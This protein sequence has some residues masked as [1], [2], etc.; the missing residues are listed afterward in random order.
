MNELPFNIRTIV[1]A[2]RRANLLPSRN[3]TRVRNRTPPIVV[4]RSP[5]RGFQQSRRIATV[6]GLGRGQNGNQDTQANSDPDS[7]GETIKQRT[8]NIEV[9]VQSPD[10]PS[11]SP[12]PQNPNPTATNPGMLNPTMANQQPGF[13]NSMGPVGG[14]NPF[15]NQRQQPGMDIM[16]GFNRFNPPNS[17]NS[18]ENNNRPSDDRS[19][20]SSNSGGGNINIGL[21]IGVGSSNPVVP[22]KPASTNTPSS[23]FGGVQNVAQNVQPT[24]PNPFPQGFNDQQGGTSS[25]DPMGFSGVPQTGFPGSPQTG[26]P[27]SPQTAFPGSPQNSFSTNDQS[28][29]PPSQISFPSNPQTGFPPNNK[30]QTNT[31]NP[32]V[33]TLQRFDQQPPSLPGAVSSS[34]SMPWNPF[35]SN[36]GN[37]GQDTG[38]LANTN[39]LIN[40]N[41]N[42]LFANNMQRSN[43]NGMQGQ[44]NSFQQSIGMVQP[45]QFNAMPPQQFNNLTSNQNFASSQLLNSQTS[46]GSIGSAVGGFGGVQ[47]PSFLQ[48][49]GNSFQQGSLMGG[50]PTIGEPMIIDNGGRTTVVVDNITFTGVLPPGPPVIKTQVINGKGSVHLNPL[51]SS[52][53][54]TDSFG[55]NFPTQ[56]QFTNPNDLNSINQNFPL[57]AENNQIFPNQQLLGIQATQGT[58]SPVEPQMNQ[59]TSFATPTSIFVNTSGLLNLTKPQGNIDMSLLSNNS[60]LVALNATNQQQM[61]D[62]SIPLNTNPIVA[63]SNNIGTAFSGSNVAVALGKGT[64]SGNVLPSGTNVTGTEGT[65]PID[66]HRHIGE[67]LLVA[68]SSISM[69]PQAFMTSTLPSVDLQG[70]STTKPTNIIVNDPQ[71]Q[72]VNNIPQDIGMSSIVGGIP[73]EISS[74]VTGGISEG[75][76]LTKTGNIPTG[77]SSTITENVPI[78][79]SPVSENILT[80][81]SSS[82]TGNVT[83]RV[84]QIQ[85][86][87]L[88]A[89][90]PQVTDNV[91]TSAE[92]NPI[93]SN[94]LLELQ[95]Q[96]QI[97]QMHRLALLRRR[98]EQLNTLRK[99]LLQIELTGNKR[100]PV[101]RT[102]LTPVKT[103][104]MR[105]LE[106]LKPAATAPKTTASSTV[107][108]MNVDSLRS[109]IEEILHGF[110]KKQNILTGLAVPSSGSAAV[111]DTSKSISP[112]LNTVSRMD[113]KSL[114]QNVVPVQ[115][116]S[117]SLPALLPTTPSNVIKTDPAVSVVDPN[118]IPPTE[119][120]AIDPN[121]VLP[122]EPTPPQ[123]PIVVDPNVAPPTEPTAPSVTDPNII[124][125]R[126]PSVHAH[127][128]VV[129]VS[130]TPVI[131]MQATESFSTILP[132]TTTV[133]P[134]VT[135]P[136]I[137]DSVGSSVGQ[138]SLSGQ[139]R[140]LFPGGIAVHP[141]ISSFRTSNLANFQQPTPPQPQ[142]NFNIPRRGVSLQGI[143]R[144][145]VSSIPEMIGGDLS[146]TNARVIAQQNRPLHNSNFNLQFNRRLQD[147]AMRS[148]VN[149]PLGRPGGVPVPML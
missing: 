85:G 47:N 24:P 51:V 129:T 123:E 70:L 35:P 10:T 89:K 8:V 74:T 115:Q 86:D 60:T 63:T 58:K 6:G 42:N 54:A 147:V 97:L 78:K 13:M 61:I 146:S 139:K 125:V 52:G 50:D 103:K 98:E 33:P 149:I 29:F 112:N 18:I 1:A 46:T 37:F 111:V 27:G 100:Q 68:T 90:V 128:D 11:P 143:R 28:A 49:A 23:Q 133:M 34:N 22:P 104:D 26:F 91:P 102:P 95:R 132:S 76:S 140:N 83:D 148:N 45:N 36:A 114:Q 120:T 138:P 32:S 2:A 48:N 69:Q 75:V 82:L 126:D 108:F 144:G 9:N 122:T 19:S 64:S 118:A 71:L 40:N 59:D 94:P 17:R 39:T 107:A 145:G 15:P 93:K 117:T 101:Q 84:G 142:W 21:G 57:S 80:G 12:T 62:I 113:L 81:I 130:D 137:I 77:L 73:K 56:L 44:R 121:A 109:L 79:S 31:N 16:N 65:G 55:R 25:F 4:L 134:P 141:E 41:Q 127:S 87:I 106:N 43:V 88:Q 119:P 53:A 14:I 66:A 124:L 38:S 131:N 92:L 30:F 99:Q 67:H 135:S 5:N 105:I 110:F 116:R 96:Q 7:G 136:P 20:S 72:V 3:G